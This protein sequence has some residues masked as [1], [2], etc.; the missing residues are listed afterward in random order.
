MGMT[1]E[2][3]QHKAEPTQLSPWP[4][5]GVFVGATWALDIGL[6]QS[7]SDHR[8]SLAIV[9]AW[10]AMT[11]AM[12]TPTTIPMLNSLREILGNASQD[13]WWMFVAG[14]V[15]MW[16]SFAL[17]G[18]GLQIALSHTELLSDHGTLTSR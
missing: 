15:F 17:V 6:H 14:Y 1:S 18:G 11:A 4:L 12:M 13:T 2:S 8:N 3:V 9:A 10:F 16:S 5:F 7:V